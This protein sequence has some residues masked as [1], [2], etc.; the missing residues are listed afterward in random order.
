MG[1]QP[2]LAPFISDMGERLADAHL[3]IA[4]AGASTVTEL[5]VAGRP[6]ILIPYPYAM[7]DHQ[8]ANAKE[9]AGT[10][11]GWSFAESQ[12][13]AEALAAKIAELA[14]SP[15]MLRDAAARA[16][17]SSRPQAAAALADLVESVGGL[18]PAPSSSRE[19][20]A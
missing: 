16:A 6:A 3:A 18:A 15:A 10:G 4:R 2:T 11:A 7:D 17:A 20:A 19:T 12:L 5:G 13:T 9:V 8:T 14:S 1:L